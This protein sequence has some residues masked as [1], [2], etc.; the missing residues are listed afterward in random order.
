MLSKIEGKQNIR[1][2]AIY[3]YSCNHT[4]SVNPKTDLWIQNI[5]YYIIGKKLQW[6]IE[7][8]YYD[9]G[10]E[11]TEYERMIKDC[12]N[13]K[14]DLIIIKS[15]SRLSRNIVTI[16]EKVRQLT[17][18]GIG[19]YFCSENIYFLDEMSEENIIIFDFMA[20]IESEEKKKQNPYDPRRYAEG[21]YEV[22]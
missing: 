2:I 21:R 10:P 1:N 18:L 4:T 20:Q 8:I 13:G 16:I 11:R 14:I 7:G 12:Q 15:V 3:N 5:K 22:P 6:I 17:K 19:V 9:Y